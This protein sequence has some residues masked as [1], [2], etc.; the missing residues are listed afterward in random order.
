VGG[1]RGDRRVRGALVDN[2]LVEP[3]ARAWVEEGRDEFTLVAAPLAVVG[4]TGSPADP[5]AVF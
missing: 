2:A 4:G 3:L 5:I 1:A